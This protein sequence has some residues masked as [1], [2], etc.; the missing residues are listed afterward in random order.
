MNMAEKF[1]MAF[2]AKMLDAIA[3][4]K[5]AGGKVNY[6]RSFRCARPDFGEV[7]FSDGSVFVVHFHDGYHMGGNAYPFLPVP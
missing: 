6:I 5:A 2:P 3:A 7:K 1:K 4:I